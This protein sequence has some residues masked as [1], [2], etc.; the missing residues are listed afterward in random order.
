VVT[1]RYNDHY[2]SVFHTADESGNSSYIPFVDIRHE[3]DHFLAAC[4]A[5]KGRSMTARATN[6]FNICSRLDRY[7]SPRRREDTFGLAGIKAC[8]AIKAAVA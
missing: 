4:L 6:L 5:R 2:F 7:L 8:A 3:R 1:L